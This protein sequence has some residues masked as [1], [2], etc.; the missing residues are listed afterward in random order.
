MKYSHS[1]EQ[2]Y[3]LLNIKNGCNWDELRKSYRVLIHKW[4]PD[5]CISENEKEAATSKLK[6]LNTAYSQ[7]SDYYQQHG[8]LPLNSL[9]HEHEDKLHG[10]NI[11][12]ETVN[13]TSAESEKS[14][15]TKQEQGYNFP[16]EINKKRSPAFKFSLLIISLIVIYQY[17]GINLNSL[18]TNLDDLDEYTQSMEHSQEPSNKSKIQ[19]DNKNTKLPA[20]LQNDLEKTSTIKENFFSYGSSIGEVIMIQGPPERTEGDIWYYGKSEIHFSKGIVTSWH[21]SANNP[22]KAEITS[23]LQPNEKNNIRQNE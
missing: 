20:N 9:P 16:P 15:T 3:S 6:D 8:V 4:H 7:L 14:K 13:P 17:R 23:Y 10:T 19:I 18:A 21:R 5:R 12:Q 22:L 11:N 1:F 2:C